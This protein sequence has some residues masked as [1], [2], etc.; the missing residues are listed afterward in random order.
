[1][2]RRRDLLL[3][4]AR[5][6][7]SE[8]VLRAR[9]PEVDVRTEPRLA[10]RTDLM[11]TNR[12][13]MELVDRMLAA[14]HNCPKQ[15]AAQQHV[16]RKPPVPRRE[17]QVLCI[18]DDAEY[19]RALQLRLNSL[20]I[21]VLRASTGLDGYCDAVAQPTDAILLDYQVPNGPGDYILRQ[22]KANPATR[23]IPVIVITGRTDHVL[24]KTMLNHGAAKFL[25]KPLDFGK[26]ITELSKHFADLDCVAALLA[27]SCR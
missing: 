1:M 25:Q 7:A 12:R 10:E 9:A 20:G 22:L 26:L 15:A 23:D 4:H 27:I 8:L 21:N 3:K 14:G 19:T 17:P 11:T 18:D 6:L 16:M 5:E 24:E 13:F 2:T